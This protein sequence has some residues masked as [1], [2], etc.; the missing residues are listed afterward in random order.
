MITI[1]I[2]GPQAGGK[3]T[4]A[5]LITKTLA[6]VPGLNILHA[7]EP[8]HRTRRKYWE[9]RLPAPHV[10]MIEVP[11]YGGDQPKT[12]G[13]AYEEL[14]ALM[15]NPM[16]SGLSRHVPSK[17]YTSSSAQVLKQ[18]DDAARKMGEAIEFAKSAGAEVH[19]DEIRHVGK[20][21]ELGM[22]YQGITT[23]D[24]RKLSTDEIETRLVRSE[25]LMRIAMMYGAGPDAFLDF[26]EMASRGGPQDDPKDKTFMGYPLSD[27]FERKPDIPQ[28]IHPRK[29][30]HRLANGSKQY[31]RY[32]LLEPT[33]KMDGKVIGEGW[34][35]MTEKEYSYLTYKR[36][37]A[38][39]LKSE[40][41]LIQK[42][43]KYD[44]ETRWRL[45]LNPV[46]GNVWIELPYPADG[47]NEF[48][49]QSDGLPKYN[50]DFPAKPGL[51]Y[52]TKKP[53]E[54]MQFKYKGKYAGFDRAL[55]NWYDSLV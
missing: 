9:D 49:P 28:S 52:Q 6:A 29:I 44:G 16:E 50:G 43:S 35:I 34:L 46:F 48:L 24:H 42:D 8:P 37:Q 45:V 1:F 31:H 7:G 25:R 17:R 11:T 20:A 53:L 54:L 3:T 51:R 39:R 14:A 23:L 36:D 21:P 55:M 32:H 10:M 19:G 47:S 12:V 33:L 2:A 5:R 15:R 38:D 4:V 30:S 41:A 13:E 22:P 40:L 26:L 27:F 18:S